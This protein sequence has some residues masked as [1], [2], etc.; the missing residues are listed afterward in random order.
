[1]GGWRVPLARSPPPLFDRVTIQRLPGDEG[2]GAR[3]LT[4]LVDLLTT[5]HR[6]ADDAEPGDRRDWPTARRSLGK[7]LVPARPSAGDLI[8]L[9]V[10]AG[11]IAGGFGSGHSVC[12]WRA[13]LGVPCPG[14]GM[15]RALLSL[16]RGDLHAAWQFNPGSFIVAPILSG[17]A[18]RHVWLQPDCQRRRRFFGLVLLAVTATRGFIILA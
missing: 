7:W 15:T 3:T 17:T 12:L 16:A 13:V 4:E 1:V 14:C 8:G 2:G 9:L 10:V 18:A 5:T 11:I 6:G